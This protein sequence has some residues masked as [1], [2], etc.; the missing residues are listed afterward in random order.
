VVAARRREEMRTIQGS[1]WRYVQ[2][3]VAF[4]SLKRKQEVAFEVRS[5]ERGATVA[6]AEFRRQR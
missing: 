2:V 3:D 5:G 6:N 1:F 4:A